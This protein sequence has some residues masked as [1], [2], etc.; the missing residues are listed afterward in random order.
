VE[1]FPQHGVFVKNI[2]R[3]VLATMLLFGAVATASSPMGCSRTEVRSVA[4][5]RNSG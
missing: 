2:V 5:Q 3:L 4:V 1:Q